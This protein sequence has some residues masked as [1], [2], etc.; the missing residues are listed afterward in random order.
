MVP[1]TPGTEKEWRH[2]P[3]DG[4]VA[5]GA[6]WGRGADRRQGL[7]WSPCSKALDGPGQARAST[8]RRT[9]IIVSGH[10]EEVRG[11][12]PGAA[13]ALL[14]SRGVTAEFVLDE[15]GWR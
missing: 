7:A 10:D 15:G 11:Q 6:V 4:V 8:P 13:A 2:P 1:V 3:F 9:V 14:K 5:D 12:G